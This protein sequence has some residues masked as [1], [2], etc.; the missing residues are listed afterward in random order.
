MGYSTEERA[1]IR[2]AVAELT[3]IDG[4]GDDLDLSQLESEGGRAV[5]AEIRELVSTAGGPKALLQGYASLC[6]ELLRIVSIETGASAQETL[7][8]IS[9]SLG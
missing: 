1:A 3:W 8:R 6:R 2:C 7:Q 5:Q 4:L 9:R